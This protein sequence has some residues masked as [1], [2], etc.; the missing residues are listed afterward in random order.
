MDSFPQQAPTDDTAHRADLIRQIT[1]SVHQQMLYVQDVEA[2]RWDSREGRWADTIRSVYR[3][4]HSLL[5]HDT[6]LPTDM[7]EQLAAANVNTICVLLDF[8]LHDDLFSREILAFP[9]IK[10]DL[11]DPLERAIKDV[12]EAL[13]VDDLTTVAPDKREGVTTLIN[14]A[15]GWWG[16]IEDQQGFIEDICLEPGLVTLVM[17]HPNRELEILQY[18]YAREQDDKMVDL[19]YLRLILN[20]AKPISSGVL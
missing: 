1:E 6:D 19:D 7:L 4:M 18:I 8:E 16:Y 15:M 10:T 5:P 9:G 3:D 2:S 20:T 13:E 14:V 11:F 12:K 17:E